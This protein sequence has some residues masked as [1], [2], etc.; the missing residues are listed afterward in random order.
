M[1]NYRKHIVQMTIVIINTFSCMLSFSTPNVNKSVD[2]YLNVKCITDKDIST[3][4]K[5]RISEII[6]AYLCHVK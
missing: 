2:S 3:T 1:L 5:Y 6:T 4:L